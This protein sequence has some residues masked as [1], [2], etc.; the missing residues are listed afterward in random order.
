MLI[1][2]YRRWRLF[3]HCLKTIDQQVEFYGARSVRLTTKAGGVLALTL[4]LPEATVG[5]L[6]ERF[7]EYADQLN[8]V[9]PADQRMNPTFNVDWFN[10]GNTPCDDLRAVHDYYRDVF[11]YW[12]K[13]HGL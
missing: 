8:A 10:P 6:V 2:M 5:E 13:H 11:A 1:K 7:P 3:R 12:E 4:T 9:G